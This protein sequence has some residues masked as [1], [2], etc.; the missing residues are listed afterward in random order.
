MNLTCRWLLLTE[1]PAH[2]FPFCYLQGTIVEIEGIFHEESTCIMC[3][4]VK[5]QTWKQAVYV[6]THSLWQ[7]TYSYVPF[8]HTLFLIYVAFGITIGD[9]GGCHVIPELGRDTGLMS[10]PGEVI[11]QTSLFKLCVA[12]LPSFTWPIFKVLVLIWNPCACD[13]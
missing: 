2:P 13:L 1:R 12:E 4:V 5:K 11:G 10:F 7:C 8:D 6:W 9:P 3:Y